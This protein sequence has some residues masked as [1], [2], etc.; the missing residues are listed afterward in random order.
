MKKLVYG[1]VI[2][3]T[4]AEMLLPVIGG[5]NLSISNASVTGPVLVADG[6]PNPLPL[7][8]TKPDPPAMA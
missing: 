5:V 7:P 1:A 2:I 6:G 8:P 3:F 4:A